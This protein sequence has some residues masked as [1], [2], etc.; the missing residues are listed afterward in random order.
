MTLMT[1]RQCGNDTNIK[2]DRKINGAELR[3]QK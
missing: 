2:T 1:L 3:V